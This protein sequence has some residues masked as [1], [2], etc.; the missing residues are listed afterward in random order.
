LQQL[1]K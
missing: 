1:S